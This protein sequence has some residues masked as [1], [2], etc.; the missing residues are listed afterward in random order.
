MNAIS[1]LSIYHHLF[2]YCLITEHQIALIHL[3]VAER[4]HLSDEKKGHLS[5]NIA[6]LYKQKF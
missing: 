6:C 3:K 1:R 2:K 4:L 5:I